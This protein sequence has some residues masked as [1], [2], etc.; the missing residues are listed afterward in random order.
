MSGPAPEEA[1]Y[2]PWSTFLTESQSMGLAGERRPNVSGMSYD[3]LVRLAGSHGNV[4]NARAAMGLNS[5][6]LAKAVDELRQA[7]LIEFTDSD[8]TVALTAEGRALVAED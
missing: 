5:V 2:D 8:E 6:Q 3:F 7:N 1:S 4:E